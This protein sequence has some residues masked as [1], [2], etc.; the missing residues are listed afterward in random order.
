MIFSLFYKKTNLITSII[1]KRQQI[2]DELE[3]GRKEYAEKI[4]NIN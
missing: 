3:R 4:V 1:S 2:I